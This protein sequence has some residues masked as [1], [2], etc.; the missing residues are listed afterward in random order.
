MAVP[1]YFSLISKT[2]LTWFKEWVFQTTEQIFFN[3]LFWFFVLS[4]FLTSFAFL[5]NTLSEPCSQISLLHKGFLKLKCNFTHSHSKCWPSSSY[6]PP[7]PLLQL[8]VH[9]YSGTGQL[10]GSSN[11]S[12]DKPM[13]RLLGDKLHKNFISSLHKLRNF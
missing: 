5:S 11:Q 4:F 3:W 2:L 12:S 9:P 1:C 8:L 6:P 7:L 13:P 10:S